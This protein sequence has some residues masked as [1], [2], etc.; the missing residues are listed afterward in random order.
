MT[1][2]CNQARSVNLR[3]CAYVGDAAGRPKN[4]KHGMKKDFSDSDRAFAANIGIQFLTP[5]MFFL[6]ESAPR[7]DWRSEFDPVAWLRLEES[8]SQQGTRFSGSSITKPDQELIVFCGY[9]A[10][11][12]STFAK[13]RLVSKG[14][15]RVN[16]D[17]LKTFQKCQTA[18]VNAL[19]TFRWFL[20]RSTQIVHLF[21]IS[22]TSLVAFMFIFFCLL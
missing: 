15:L 9:P 14:Y 8:I 17:E 21:A 11:G 3:S 18:V 20:G 22:H 16:Q 13:T 19:G 6:K 10:S 4:W 5:E 7:M 12:K 2:E 1:T